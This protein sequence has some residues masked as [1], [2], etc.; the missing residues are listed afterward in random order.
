M[1]GANS[2]FIVRLKEQMPNACR[3]HCFLNRQALAAKTLPK[4]YCQVLNVII[5][6]VKSIEG[7]ALQT[8]LFRRICEDMGA[9]HQNLFYHREVRWLSR[10]KVLTGVWEL[11]AK[12]LIYL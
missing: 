4:E 3:T 5:Q 9:L 12:L 8:Q 2:G 6:M 7:K 1:T 10:D 11:R